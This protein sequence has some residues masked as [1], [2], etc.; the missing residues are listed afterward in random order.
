MKPLL[1]TRPVPRIVL[2]IGLSAFWIAEQPREIPAAAEIAAPGTPA[3]WQHPLFP[4]PPVFAKAATR[5][6]V[7]PNGG[8]NKVPPKA[9]A[10]QPGTVALVRSSFAG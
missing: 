4:C 6:P 5:R 7:R 8:F 9:D 10:L 1:L 2:L 3:L